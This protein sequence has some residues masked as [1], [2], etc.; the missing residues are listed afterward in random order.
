MVLGRAQFVLP[1]APGSTSAAVLDRRPASRR[2]RPAAWSGPACAR[3][4][5]RTT[6]AP[7]DLRQPI[8]LHEPANRSALRSRRRRFESSGGP[9]GR[10]H[11]RRGARYAPGTPDVA[12]AAASSVRAVMPSLGNRRYRWVATVRWER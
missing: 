8:A 9:W 12:R 1:T 3:G 11:L 2:H 4:P 5:R 7:G 6:T 10:V